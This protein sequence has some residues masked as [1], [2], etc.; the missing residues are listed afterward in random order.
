MRFEDPGLPP[1]F[2]SCASSSSTVELAANVAVFNTAIVGYVGPVAIS[3]TGTSD[4]ESALAGDGTLTL[5]VVGT[6]TTSSRLT[7]TDLVGTYRRI[8]TAMALSLSGGCVVND[9]SVSRVT[10]T[11]TVSFTP[12]DPRAGVIARIFEAALTGGFVV[13]PE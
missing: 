1:A 2:G 5:D 13:R 6:G 9:Y 10:V 3:G 11:A 8:E 7:C 12:T 4:C